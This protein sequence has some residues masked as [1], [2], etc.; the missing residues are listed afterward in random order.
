MVHEQARELGLLGEMGERIGG[1]VKLE[2]L[3]PQGLEGRAPGADHVSFANGG[4]TRVD[5]PRIALSLDGGKPLEPKHP[6]VLMVDSIVEGRYRNRRPLRITGWVLWGVGS[7]MGTMMMVLSTNDTEELYTLDIRNKA[8]FY[9]G[10]AITV[11]A[12]GVGIPL[13]VQKD[14]A[15]INV[16]PLYK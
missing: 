15:T 13:A 14:K 8:A 5:R 16:Y 10:A 3:P 4:V 12:F 1:P 11:I 2:D 7:V 9:A 6:T